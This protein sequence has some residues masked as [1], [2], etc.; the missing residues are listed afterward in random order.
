M[1]AVAAQAHCS[2]GSLY[3]W[4][5]DRDGLLLALIERNADRA[6]EGVIQALVD[7]GES[8]VVLERFAI[9]LLEMLTGPVSVSLN[10]AA[11]SS[12]ELAEKLLTSGRYKVGPLV[13]EYLRTLHRSGRLWVPD[14]PAAFRLLYGLVVQDSQITVLLGRPAPMP[15]QLRRQAR[16]GVAAFLTYATPAGDDPD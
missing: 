6:A 10:R 12:P 15:A 11:M 5:G 8:S 16:R 4:Y 13:E 9:G 2:K 3:A 1:V 7:D 14:A